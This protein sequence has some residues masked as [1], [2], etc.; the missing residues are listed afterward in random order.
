MSGR[1]LWSRARRRP[2]RTP[3]SQTPLALFWSICAPARVRPRPRSPRRPAQGTVRPGDPRPFR[4]RRRGA[5]SPFPPP[6]QRRPRPKF[7]L[8]PA[9]LGGIKGRSGADRGECLAV[10]GN[11]RAASGRSHI[12]EYAAAAAPFGGIRIRR[13]AGGGQR[14]AGAAR[15]PWR[16]RAREPARAAA[17]SG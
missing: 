1:R 6:A 8:A 10:C 14:A 5:P 11:I 12:R 13:G 9:P 17:P 2:S 16:E 15:R 3:P 7:A 4:S